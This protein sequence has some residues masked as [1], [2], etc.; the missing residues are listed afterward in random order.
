ML[1][2]VYL[3][4]AAGRTF[5]R[6]WQLDVASPAEAV[7]ALITLRPALK[8]VLRKGYWRVIVGRPRIRYAIEAAWLQMQAGA[9]AIHIV[10]AHP[11]RGGDDAIANVGKVVVGVV[12]VAAAVVFSVFLGPLIAGAMI[13]VG[14]SLVFG[15]VAGLL[16][17]RMEAPSSMST[18]MARP[19]DR[20]SFL[21]MG[22]TNNTQQG[23]P[24]PIVMGTHLCGS[25]LVSGGI[26]TEDI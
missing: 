18:D 21:F 15:G 19:E 9:Q 17:P 16:T 1:R 26:N 10:P 22:A 3:Y 24:V 2:E 20:P 6:R 23:G 25:V 5:G 8:E 12:L 13:S 7:R 14:L 4:G 11:P